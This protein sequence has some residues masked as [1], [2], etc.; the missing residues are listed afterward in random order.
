MF[1]R[2]AGRQIIVNQNIS[3]PDANSFRMSKRQV[4][5]EA[6]QVLSF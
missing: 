3:T 1:D 5:R 2:G 6:K 4:A